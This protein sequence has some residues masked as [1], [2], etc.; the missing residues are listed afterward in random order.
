M[1]SN[2]FTTISDDLNNISNDVDDI[3]KNIKKIMNDKKNSTNENFKYIG[4]KLNEVVKSQWSAYYKIKSIEQEL[5]NSRKKEKSLEKRIRQ[6]EN[7]RKKDKSLEKRIKVLETRLNLNKTMNTQEKQDMD[8]FGFKKTQICDTIKEKLDRVKYCNAR[9]K[10]LEIIED[11]FRYTSSPEVL[12][13]VH[14][15]DNFKIQLDKKMIEI[16]KE[17]PSRFLYSCYR[18]VFKTRIPIS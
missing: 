11:L 13:F 14:Y 1:S 15:F 16:Y 6:L 10:K 5:E 8:E 7:S 9:V 3:T 12:K 4:K 2:N 17:E 18:K